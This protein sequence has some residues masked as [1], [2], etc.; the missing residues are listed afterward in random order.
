MAPVL[1]ERRAARRGV[2]AVEFAF[3]FPLFILFL[4]GLIDIGRGFMVS[5]L[6][7]DAARVGARA[8]VLPSAS[9]STVTAAVKSLMER[10]SITDYT[11]TIMVNGKESDLA[12]AVS[13]DEVKV[14]VSVPTSSVSWVP[15]YK[16]L[17]GSLSAASS[18]RRE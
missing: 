7:S 6:L 5:Q 4:F 2:T 12:T 16:F 9:N 1:P 3:V 8:G 13:N 14:T 10:E 11:T 17:S 18:L 15:V